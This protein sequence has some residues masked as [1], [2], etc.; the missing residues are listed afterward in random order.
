MELYLYVCFCVLAAIFGACFGSFANVLIYRLPAGESLVK[1]ASHCTTCGKKILKRDNVPIISYVALRG[2]CR[3]CSSKINPRY[4]IV[5][6]ITALVFLGFAL[7]SPVIGFA[8][9]VFCMAFSV[10]VIAVAFIDFETG[11]IPDSLNVTILVIGA[12]AC[13]YSAV[14]GGYV[15]WI[16]RLV[17]LGFCLV[18]FGGAYFISKLILKREGLG[19][20]DVKFTAAC[21]LFLG[22]KSAFFATLVSTILASVILV[23]IQAKNKSEEKQKEYP[24]APFLAFGILVAAFVGEIVVNSYLALF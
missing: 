15:G 20:G 5:E 3:F 8:Y 17:G 13:V 14:F 19:F 4:V 16:S 12:L 9:S 10:P 23:I 11:Y 22:I 21:G 1:G 24:F 18:F 2:K 6:S 7:L